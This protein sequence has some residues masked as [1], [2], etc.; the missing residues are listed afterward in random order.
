VPP[1]AGT[2]APME[3]GWPV[4]ERGIRESHP[5]ADVYRVDMDS[6]AAR[7]LTFSS[8][9]TLGMANLVAPEFVCY[10]ST[11]GCSV[12]ASC[13]APWRFGPQTLPG[14]RLAARGPTDEHSL[15]FS[16]PCNGCWPRVTQCWRPITGAAPVMDYHTNTPFTTTGALWIPRICWP[17]PITWLA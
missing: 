12:P 16:A 5:A 1:G 10:P 13:I 9:P 6:G 11:R 15:Q 14:H 3:P 4:A 17:P 8:L 2:A 7:Q